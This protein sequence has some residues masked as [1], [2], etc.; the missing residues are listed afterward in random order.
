MKT[1]LKKLNQK[2]IKIGIVG[3]GYVGLDLVRLF[4]GEKYFVYGFDI[5]IEKI[6]ILKKN[7]SHINYIPNSDIKKIS[8]FTEYNNKFS[9]IK[10]VM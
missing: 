2:K 9:S 10:N 3:L 6:N 7:K 1:F 5:D 4:A 8:K